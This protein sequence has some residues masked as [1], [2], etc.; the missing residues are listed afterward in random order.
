VARKRKPRSGGARRPVARAD[1]R[2]RA[3]HATAGD[4]VPFEKPER[5]I[6]L[7]PVRTDTGELVFFPAPF[8]W[9]LDLDLAATLRERGEKARRRAWR[10]PLSPFDVPGMAGKAAEDETATHDA[11][12]YLSAAVFLAFAAIESY[13]NEKLDLLDT[14]A[15]VKSGRKTVARDDMARELQIEE[16]LKRAVPLVTGRHVA[17]DSR[18]WARF[19]A[20]K[21]LRDELVHLKERGYSPHPDAPSPYSRLMRGD[22]A[23]CV[24][25]AAELIHE[26]EGSWPEGAPRLFEK[27]ERGKPS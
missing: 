1:R 6:S 2:T 14:S 20:L 11:L 25:D 7:Q 12:G 13:A 16:K 10:G 26:M 18:L 23:T 19:T 4:G 24:E 22:A 9:I 5:Y 17:G 27:G 21:E 8:A 3:V 15:E